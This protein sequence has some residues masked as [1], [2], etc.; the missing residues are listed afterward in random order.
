MSSRHNIFGFRHNHPLELNCGVV[1]EN[2]DFP[3]DLPWAILALL[4]RGETRQK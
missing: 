1:R 4:T 2:N 3:H